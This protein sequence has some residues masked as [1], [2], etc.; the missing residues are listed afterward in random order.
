MDL[1]CLPTLAET[2]QCT[3]KS[4]FGRFGSRRRWRAAGVFIGR[5]TLTKSAAPCPSSQTEMNGWKALW[6][7]Q[8]LE[9]A[10]AYHSSQYWLA[11]PMRESFIFFLCTEEELRISAKVFPI[12]FHGSI[13]FSMASKH[14]ADIN[15]EYALASTSRKHEWFG[16]SYLWPGSLGMPPVEQNFPTSSLRPSSLQWQLPPPPQIDFVFYNWVTFKSRGNIVRS[17]TEGSGGMGPLPKSHTQLLQMH[18]CNVLSHPL[19][20]LA[21][22]YFHISL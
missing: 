1:S 14:S 3:W 9:R 13:S 22:Q 6:N 4:A 10:S 8:T 5:G 16:A 15:E 21:C 18:L 17:G 7:L 11:G 2:N 12:L 19:S 20:S